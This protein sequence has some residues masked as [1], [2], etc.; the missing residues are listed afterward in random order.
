MSIVRTIELVLNTG[1]E[2][3]IVADTEKAANS[4]RVTAFN[5]RRAMKGLAEDIGIQKI[6]EDEKWFL[7]IFKRGITEAQH[8]RRDKETGK[9]VLVVQLTPEQ[10]RM[11]MLM[12]KAGH[13]E[14]EIQEQIKGV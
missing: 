3:F 7:R 8:F 4:M 9:L 5:I 6:E 12:R 1:E 13:S 2:E 11:A 14:E 10:E